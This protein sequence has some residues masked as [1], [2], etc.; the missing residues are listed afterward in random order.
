MEEG[1]PMIS[2]K[3]EWHAVKQKWYVRLY[4]CFF[5]LL[6][7]K[8]F[9]DESEREVF[10]SEDIDKIKFDTDIKILGQRTL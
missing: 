4:R 8:V 3:K 10:Y 6:P 5:P 7:I 1:E 2:N 9:Y